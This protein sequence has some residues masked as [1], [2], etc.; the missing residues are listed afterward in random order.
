MGLGFLFISGSIRAEQIADWTGI[1]LFSLYGLLNYDGALEFSSMY[2]EFLNEH[3][4][5]PLL[6]FGGMIILFIKRYRQLGKINSQKQRRNKA[7]SL[8]VFESLFLAVILFGG[9]IGNIYAVFPDAISNVL[10]VLGI[11]IPAIGLSLFKE[12]LAENIDK[13]I[14]S[15]KNMKQN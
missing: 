13:F 14:D 1:K 8:A 5:I 7:I 11:V 4:L 10:F 3:S 12:K 15:R 2:H 6:F 9:V